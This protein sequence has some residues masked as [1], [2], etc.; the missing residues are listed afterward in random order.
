MSRLER[1]RNPEPRTLMDRQFGDVPAFEKNTAGCRLMKAVDQIEKSRFPCTVRTDDCRNFAL[2]N[3]KIHVVH[4]RQSTE[5]FGDSFYF[6]KCHLKFP[7]LFFSGFLWNR[8]KVFAFFRQFFMLQLGFDLVKT[9]NNS[10]RE[11]NN[12]QHQDRTENQQVVFLV[13]PEK[14]LKP[15]KQH[16]SYERTGQRTDSSNYQ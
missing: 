3:F 5:L 2:F 11:E 7:L 1:P 4:R 10:S 15:D 12:H 8:I 14:L 16:R 13:A 9:T 6:N